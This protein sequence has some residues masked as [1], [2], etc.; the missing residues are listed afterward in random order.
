VVIQRGRGTVRQQQII[1]AA[2]KLIV[3]YGS[4]HVTVKKMARQIGVSE[5]AIYRHFNSKKEILSFL[6]DD[7]EAT[8][9][10]GLEMSDSTDP[11]EV[12]EKALL[13]QISD[14]EQRRGMSFLIIAEIIS[15]G[16]RKLKK[17]AYQVILNFLERLQNLLS[18]AVESGKIRKDI[19]PS[20]MAK[21]LF[22][23]MQGLVTVWTL[24][25]YNLDLEKDF[26]ASW[27]F[28]RKSITG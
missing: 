2:K 3:K 26:Q 7:V 10:A 19:E 28:F 1:S 23:I 8:L 18:I 24:S 20:A 9:L 15:L 17:K 27:D 22:G 6:L 13:H 4:E 25:H 16:D 14:S 11:L 5:A 12:I 21:M